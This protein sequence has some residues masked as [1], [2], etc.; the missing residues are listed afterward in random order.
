MYSN[1]GQRGKGALYYKYHNFIRK[2][3]PGTEAEALKR[4]KKKSAYS[5]LDESEDTNSVRKLRH[6]KLDHESQLTH[7]RGC[8]ATRMN[9]VH[10]QGIKALLSQWDQ[11]AGARGYD[12][13]CIY[14]ITFF[15]PTEISD[16]LFS[17]L[18]HLFIA[19]VRFRLFA[20]IEE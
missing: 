7:W 9:L 15:D 20:S 2:L 14:F 10:A 1:K 18:Y 17:Y 6:E 5:E 12:F 16:V 19:R 11:Y 3:T 13:V 4:K 8:V